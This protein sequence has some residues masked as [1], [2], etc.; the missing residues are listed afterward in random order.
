M[1]N[2]NITKSGRYTYVQY[3]YQSLNDFSMN[4]HDNANI[5]DGDGDGERNENPN[6]RIPR[7]LLEYIPRPQEVSFRMNDRQLELMYITW[8]AAR[9]RVRQQV[10]RPDLPFAPNPEPPVWRDEV[11]AM[12]VLWIVRE[13]RMFEMEMRELEQLLGLRARTDGGTDACHR[14]SEGGTALSSSFQI[15]QAL[16]ATAAVRGEF[17]PSLARLQVGL[18]LICA[19]SYSCRIEV[20]ISAEFGPIDC[21]DTGCDMDTLESKPV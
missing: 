12:M 16:A 17:T 10:Y 15:V 20:G 1:P 11:H 9:M 14:G 3:Y 8:A 18:A 4:G 19:Y 13:R 21:V 2:D 5:R 7:R 6:H